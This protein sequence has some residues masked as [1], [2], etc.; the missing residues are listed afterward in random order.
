MISVDIPGHGKIEI[1]NLV[2]DYNGTLAKDGILIPGVPELIEDLS[3]LV[4]LYVITADTFGSVEFE[5]KGLPITIIGIETKDEREAKLGLIQKLSSRVTASIGNGN[6]DAWMLEESRIGICI[7]GEEGCS[8]KA[9]NSANIIISDIKN[10][11][12]LFI[13]PNRLKATLRF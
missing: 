3:H 5:M 2:L 4:D 9:M 7:I 10:A 12:E 11:L 13:Y 1:K 6:N 8:M